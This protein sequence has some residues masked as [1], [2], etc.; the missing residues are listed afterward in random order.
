VL[1]PASFPELAL[2][3][4]EESQRQAV[5]AAQAV[6]CLVA[7]A[8][9]LRWACSLV[10]LVGPGSVMVLK[11]LDS[12]ESLSARRVI[13]P[14]HFHFAA[15]SIRLSPDAPVCRLVPSGNRQASRKVLPWAKRQPSWEASRRAG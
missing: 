11:R 4:C 12:A 15:G 8:T 13:L 7:L 14:E 10:I 9:E 2:R 3:R 6:D 1:F 5:Q